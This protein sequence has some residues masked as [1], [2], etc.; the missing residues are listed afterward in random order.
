M[1][2]YHEELVD[3]IIV[4]ERFRKDYGDLEPLKESIRKVGVLEPLI[5]DRELN[6]LAGGRRIRAV[7]ELGLPRVPVLYFDQI[8][9]VKA[10]E[11]ELE[12]NIGRLDL[13]PAEK[14]LLVREVHRLKTAQYAAQADKLTTADVKSSDLAG[15][16]TD[17][18]LEGR[19]RAP[20]EVTKW[21]QGMTA[22]LIGETDQRVSE[23]LSIADALDIMPELKEAESVSEMKRWASRRLEEL[24]REWA[25]RQLRRSGKALS[26]GDIIN[27]DSIIELAK[28][29][30]HC[31]DCVIIDPPYGVIQPG[32][33][34]RY[35]NLH[36][37]D[38]PDL[39]MAHLKLVAVELKRVAKDDAHIY[40][41]FGIKMWVETRAIFDGLGFDVDPIPLV[42]FKNTGSVVNWDFRY[43]N[44]WEP[45]LFISNHTRRLN[46]KRSTGNVF[47]YD[48]VPSDQ[49]T[50]IA[51]K[52]LELIKELVILSTKPGELVL[53][54]YAGS[55]VVG[56]AAKSTG[57]R[58]WLCE[59]NT[60]QWN[61]AN[62]RV[63]NTQTPQEAADSEDLSSQSLGG[64][65]PNEGTI[66]S[67]G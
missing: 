24:E 3:V 37:D 66:T 41:F 26:A 29:P 1:T 15:T 59:K 65:S 45:I 32:G 61:G 42:W 20:R 38:N 2:N 60:D 52:P 35:E 27:G 25:M 43:A 49:R 56:V 54:C 16:L 67:I 12:E 22:E 21:T 53:D 58:W 14:A 48:S 19:E 64:Q 36:F 33:L 8:D 46:F 4:G 31:A 7:K 44:H 40:V 17:E 55:G 30:D 50:N 18:G 23:Q 34:G 51:E 6:L 5:L 57:R 9:E 47:A 11:I 62:V 13:S 63:A 39:A 28:L 10:R